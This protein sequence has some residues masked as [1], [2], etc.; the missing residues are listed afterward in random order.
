MLI[1]AALLLEL[2][3]VKLENNDLTK[4]VKLHKN[5]YQKQFCSYKFTRS[6]NLI[7][8]GK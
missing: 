5:E 6:L 8:K 3:K 4:N 1:I 2:V 7:K